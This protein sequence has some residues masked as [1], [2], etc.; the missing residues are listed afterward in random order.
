MTS[1]PV[2]L[3]CVGEEPGLLHTRCAV[4]RHAAHG[5]QKRSVSLVSRRRLL[6]RHLISTYVGGRFLFTLWITCEL[7]P[8]GDPLLI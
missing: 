8:V 3:P 7:S 2:R 5:G 4:L 1:H 6:P